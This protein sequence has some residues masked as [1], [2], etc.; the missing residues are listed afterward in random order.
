MCGVCVCR[1]AA[2]SGYECPPYA[3]AVTTHSYLLFI[4]S[5]FHIYSLTGKVQD[6]NVKITNNSSWE[7]NIMS[8][9]QSVIKYFS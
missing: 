9:M 6:F 8:K 3:K 2:G 4:Q 7:Y 1:W 5:Y